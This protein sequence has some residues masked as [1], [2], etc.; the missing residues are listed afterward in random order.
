M[1]IFYS[2]FK[3]RMEFQSRESGLE[4]ISAA[5]TPSFY[6]HLKDSHACLGYDSSSGKPVRG[7]RSVASIAFSALS[8]AI[9]SSPA[10]KWPRK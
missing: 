5:Y 6:M 10:E 9:G 3:G 8:R 1:W 2:Y 7:S 4:R